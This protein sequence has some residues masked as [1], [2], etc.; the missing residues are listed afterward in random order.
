MRFCIVAIFE[1]PSLGPE[2]ATHF[3]WSQIEMFRC[4]HVMINLSDFHAQ[5]W[6]HVSIL[7][8]AVPFTS[9]SFSISVLLFLGVTSSLPVLVNF[10]KFEGRGQEVKARL[11]MLWDCA[12]QFDDTTL[13]YFPRV[14]IM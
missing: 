4:E 3:R 6:Y 7:D 14:D 2:F 11:E 9:L 10:L 8:F 1:A 5:Q 13:T 12:C